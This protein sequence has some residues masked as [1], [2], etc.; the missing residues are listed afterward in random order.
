MILDNI[1]RIF[2]VEDSLEVPL[3]RSDIEVWDGKKTGKIITIR[4]QT[5]RH[6]YVK[7]EN[8]YVERNEYYDKKI[9][10]NENTTVEELYNWYYTKKFIE[11]NGNNDTKIRKYFSFVIY[12]KNELSYK[13]LRDDE[14]VNQYDVIW[15]VFTGNRRT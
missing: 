11:S 4:G 2:G 14:I 8:G 15:F 6:M 12:P 1:L 9:L 3:I 5:G 10:I 7:T 13:V